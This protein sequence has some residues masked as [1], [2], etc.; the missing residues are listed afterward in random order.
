MQPAPIMPFLMFF[1]ALSVGCSQESPPPATVATGLEPMN[2]AVRSTRDTPV[3]MEMPAPD[4]AEGVDGYRRRASALLSLLVAGADLT[5]ARRHTEALMEFGAALVPEFVAREPQC[6][7]YL[8]AA[9]QVRTLWPDMDL[10]TIERDYHHDG[11]LPAMEDPG[12]CH[13]MK[14]LVVPVSYTHLTLPTKA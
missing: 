12:I 5:A 13:H 3:P 10:A 9:L 4:V 11:A 7:A 14:D 1:A 6:K 8:E 2:A